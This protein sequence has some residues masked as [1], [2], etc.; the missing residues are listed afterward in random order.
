MKASDLRSHKAALGGSHVGRR[1]HVQ[2]GLQRMPE[3]LGTTMNMIRLQ[4]G[5]VSSLRKAMSNALGVVV[6]AVM[7]GSGAVNAQGNAAETPAELNQQVLELYSSGKYEQAIPIAEKLLEMVE[8]EHGPD[9]SRHGHEPEQPR[10]ALSGHGRLR[11]GRAAVPARPGDPRKGA[12][13]GPSRHGHE[14]E[15][16]RRALSGHGRLRQGRAAAISAPWRSTKRR[17][18]RPIPT[19]P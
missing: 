13:P 10:R 5:L 14:P 9:A 17:S 6:I 7:L 12:R 3:Q 11:Q 2:P 15:Q 4:R 1:G 8:R 19:R 18:A 16:P